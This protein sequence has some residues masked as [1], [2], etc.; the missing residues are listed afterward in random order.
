MVTFAT[1]TIADLNPT[2]ANDIG[3]FAQ[4]GDDAASNGLTIWM[5]QTLAI[6]KGSK[7][8]DAA[9]QFI[10]FYLSPEGLATRMAAEPPQGPWAVKGVKMPDNIAAA[11]KD[12]L[13]YVDADKT[14]P[15]LEF[16]SP[17]KGPNLPQISVEVGLGM[18][19]PL[20]GAKDYDKDVVKQ[21]KQLGLPGW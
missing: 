17:I 12:I 1:G 11:T 8:I 18:K 3:F 5:P 15:A 9:K 19:T 4:P 21:A 14:T 20:Q 16:V 13:P 6:Y 2:N 10:A 7:N